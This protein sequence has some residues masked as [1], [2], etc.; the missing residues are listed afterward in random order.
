MDLHAAPLDLELLQRLSVA[1][2]PRPYALLIGAF[3]QFCQVLGIRR[4]EATSTLDVNHNWSPCVQ[5]HGP[6]FISVQVPGSNG[7]ALQLRN[8]KLAWFDDIS[9]CRSV[10]SLVGAAL[11]NVEPPHSLFRPDSE[12]DVE[13]AAKALEEHAQKN[14]AARRRVGEITRNIIEAGKL[15]SYGTATAQEYFQKWAREWGGLK[16]EKE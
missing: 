15:E 16:D 5:V 3:A 6:A 14:P 8:G 13:K 7:Y 12:E 1:V 11:E 10:H 4:S 2:A 9:D